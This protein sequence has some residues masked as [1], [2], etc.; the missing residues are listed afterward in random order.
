[1]IAIPLALV[2]LFGVPQQSDPPQ[3]AEPTRGQ[4]RE[5]AREKYESMRRAAIHI[6]QLAGSIHSE[7]DARDFVDAVAERLTEKDHMSW[8]TRSVRHRVAHAEYQTVSDPSRLIPEQRVVDLWNEYVRELDA[9]E[10]TLVTSAEVHNLRDAMYTTSRSLW[11]REGTQQL[12]TV[13]DIYALGADGKVAN[14]CRAVETLKIFH[15]MFFLFQNVRS[16]RERVQKGIL[17][18][19]EVKQREQSPKP[20]PQL[21]ASHLGVAQKANPLISAEYRYVQTHGEPDYLRL[22]QRL[23]SEL[24]PSD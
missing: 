13:P 21:A 5:Q 24:F 10:E 8:T 6:N 23:Y 7:A 3:P 14:G 11:K 18:S 12:W 9:P 1:M 4:W 22:L 15:D 20:R 19:D 17:V 2:L 16:A